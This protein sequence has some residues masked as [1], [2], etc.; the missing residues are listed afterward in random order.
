LNKFLRAL[1]SFCDK[2]K[3]DIKILVAPSL[4]VGHQWVETLTR[5]ESS[6]LN[7][8]VQTFKGLVFNMANPIL[9]SNGRRSV[10]DTGALLIDGRR[11]IAGGYRPRISRT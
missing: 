5:N 7:L 4:R 8:Q 1:A 3:F 2:H 10:S 6:I 9:T 11:H